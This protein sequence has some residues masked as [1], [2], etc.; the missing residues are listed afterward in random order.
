MADMIPR[1]DLQNIIES[2]GLPATIH[3]S[4]LFLIKTHAFAREIEKKTHE[5]R[6]R[7][8]ED[9]IV[10]ALDD[11]LIRLATPDAARAFQKLAHLVSDK[12]LAMQET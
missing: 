6:A 5:S 12:V 9:A 8:K 7:V 4:E 11:N 1:I 10:R 2:A 3:K